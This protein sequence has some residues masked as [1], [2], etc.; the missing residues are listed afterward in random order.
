MFDKE[1]ICNKFCESKNETE[2]IKI[3]QCVIARLGD[4]SKLSAGILQLN[5]PQNAISLLTALKH[6]VF[7]CEAETI[8]VL[9]DFFVNNLK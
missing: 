5:S 2:N 3:Q 7:G 8:S 4:C 1:L 9:I 6:V